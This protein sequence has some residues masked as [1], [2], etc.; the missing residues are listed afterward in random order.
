MKIGKIIHLA[1]AAAAM[2]S[3]AS[4]LAIAQTADA[5]PGA[6]P[7][8]SGVI[9]VDPHGGTLTIDVGQAGSQIISWI[10]ATFGGVISLAISTWLLTLARKLH[11]QATDAMRA[12]WQSII[13]NGLNL[14]A[15]QAEKQLEGTGA[16]KVEIKNAA[17]VKAVEYVQE[18]GAATAKK[19]GLDVA[20]ASAVE[21]IKANIE[22]MVADPNVAT[23]QSISPEKVAP[24]PVQIVDVTPMAQPPGDKQ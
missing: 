22:T 12:R 19:L 17:V 8:L 16:G 2:I 3:L 4:V 5:V 11:V 9:T 24:T 7:D 21:A 1:I 14:G 15:A 13:L 20:S 10:V 18:H 23:A 6:V